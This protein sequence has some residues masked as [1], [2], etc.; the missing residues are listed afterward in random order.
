MGAIDSIMN[1]NISQIPVI[2]VSY[3]SAELI[4]DLLLSFRSF[5]TNPITIIDGSAVEFVPGI[6]QVCSSYPDVEFI[7][8]DYNIHHG[9]GMAWAIEHLSLAGPV[10]FLDSDISFVK[11]GAL[12][13][14]LAE[15]KPDMYG[16]GAVAYVTREGFDVPY[17]EGAVPYLHPPVMLCN[18]EVMRQWPLPIKHGA[19]MFNAMLA[20]HDAGVSNLLGHVDWVISDF[21]KNTDNRFFIH[22]GQGTVMRTGGYH[23]D[24]FIESIQN[25]ETKPVVMDSPFVEA[26]VNLLALL[27]KQLKSILEVGCKTGQLAKQYKKN[28]S[29]CF[30]IGIEKNIDRISLAKINCDIVMQLDIES[31]GADFYK[32]YAQ[33]DGW[34][35]DNV[36]QKLRDPWS[37]LSKIRRVIPKNGIVISRMP[38]AQHWSIVTKLCVGDFRYQPEGLLSQSN[39][40]WFTRATI[41]ELFSQSGFKVT[42]GTSE[43]AEEPARENF[44]PGIRTLAQDAG[45]DPT[46]ATTD[47]TPTHFLVLAVP[48]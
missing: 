14:L 27:P 20:L 39:L 16:V 31:V 23:L 5:Y 33:V 9:P 37:V 45:F 34:I 10:L 24:E 8:F 11:P 28:N 2:S 40:R 13:A 30:Y 26:N 43:I 38:N 12:E 29:E 36:L 6:E 7:H 44:L 3:N 18:V 22:E 35:F 21:N 15:L 25:K 47:A 17:H 32:K 19:P 42:V 1:I 46:M 41:F 48:A 4:E